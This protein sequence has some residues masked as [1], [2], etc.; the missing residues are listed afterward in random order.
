MIDEAE[1]CLELTWVQEEEFEIVAGTSVIYIKTQ[2]WP[3][4][5]QSDTQE[6][7]CAT[8]L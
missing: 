6:F 2:N 4:Q 1:C 8:L 7:F 3:C 5:G